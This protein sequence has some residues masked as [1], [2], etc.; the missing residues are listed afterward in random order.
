MINDGS[1]LPIIYD[2]AVWRFV[3]LALND[4]WPFRPLPHSFDLHRTNQ[5]EK[6]KEIMKYYSALVYVSSVDRTKETLQP[7]R[8]SGR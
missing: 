1:K 6:L 4:V 8:V 7:Y 2:T 5:K 3:A